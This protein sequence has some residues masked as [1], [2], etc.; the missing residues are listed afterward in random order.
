MQH[1]ITVVFQG[2]KMKQGHFIEGLIFQQMTFDSAFL[3]VFSLHMALHI[4]SPQYS[5]H[6]NA[7]RH[8]K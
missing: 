1:M 8:R 4:A 2:K 6:D 7:F 3:E 5:A